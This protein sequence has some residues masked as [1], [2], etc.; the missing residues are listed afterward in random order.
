MCFSSPD[1]LAKWEKK[2]FA[3][4]L[5][6]VSLS[7]PALTWMFYARSIGPV[8]GTLRSRA[9]IPPRHARKHELSGR[10]VPSARPNRRKCIGA[11]VARLSM[12][13]QDRADSSDSSQTKARVSGI[14]DYG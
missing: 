2:I 13:G 3:M 7:D 6:C 1:A 5:H 4:T 10:L 9:L 8:A 11:A 14:L 12:T